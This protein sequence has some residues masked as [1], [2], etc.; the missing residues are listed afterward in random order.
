M[1]A[2]QPTQPDISPKQDIVL[3]T[4]LQG[5]LIK[6]QPMKSLTPHSSTLHT[7]RTSVAWGL[8][9][10]RILSLSLSFHYPEINLVPPDFVYFIKLSNL[11]II[12][13]LIK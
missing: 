2:G 11:F 9:R 7:V 6:M 5:C 4:F 12:L 10:V 1:P 8:G 3:A 13:V